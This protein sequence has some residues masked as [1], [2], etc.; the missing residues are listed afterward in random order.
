MTSD[1]RPLLDRVFPLGD[2]PEASDE[3]VAEACSDGWD[4]WARIFPVTPS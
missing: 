1:E 2:S 3:E 4:I